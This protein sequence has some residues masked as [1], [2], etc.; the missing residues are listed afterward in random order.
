MH[1]SE[2]MRFQDT[3][4][5]IGLLAILVASSSAKGISPEDRI[6]ALAAPSKGLSSSSSGG[7]SSS[8]SSSTSP[9]SSSSTQTNPFASMG[10][11]FTTDMKKMTDSFLSSMP[12]AT[13][14]E[15]N[16]S[17]LKDLMQSKAS[18]DSGLVETLSK[19]IIQSIQ[20]LAEKQILLAREKFNEEMKLKAALDQRALG[21]DTAIPSSPI[22]AI[23][24]PTNNNH[25]GKTTNSTRGL[26]S[27]E[28]DSLSKKAYKPPQ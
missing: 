7:G 18:V 27:S 6:R 20:E 4:F 2:D 10:Q 21:V 28:L 12:K 3:L 11:S 19:S 25:Q 9:S 8:K 15:K 24:E 13:T 17:F 26:F 23:T 14:E 5:Q 16:D 22:L 1:L